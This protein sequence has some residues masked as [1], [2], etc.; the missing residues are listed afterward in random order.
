MYHFYLNLDGSQLME[1]HLDFFTICQLSAFPATDTRW[2]FRMMFDLLRIVQ[3]L[4]VLLET[5]ELLQD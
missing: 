4:I 3:T 1:K 2:P 5:N